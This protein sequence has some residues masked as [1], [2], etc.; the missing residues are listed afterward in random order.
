M[1]TAH[2]RNVDTFIITILHDFKKLISPKFKHNK[3]EF[4]MIGLLL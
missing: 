4:I 1:S 3:W 2:I